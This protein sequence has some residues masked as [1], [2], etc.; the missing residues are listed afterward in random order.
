[1]VPTN[2]WLALEEETEGQR[3]SRGYLGSYIQY[4]TELNSGAQTSESTLLPLHWVS[5]WNPRPSPSF[6]LSENS[7]LATGA[8]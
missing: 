2:V 5:S 8:S 7:F 4:C 3:G 1:M 6:H